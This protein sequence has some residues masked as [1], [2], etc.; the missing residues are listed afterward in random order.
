MKILA[1][2]TETTGL[3]ARQNDIIQLAAIFL[4]G[5][6]GKLVAKGEFITYMKPRS[7]DT[8]TDEALRVNG[9][10]REQM[11]GFIGPGE[12]LY[13]FEEFLSQFIE[14]YN[15]CDKAIPL[16]YNVSFDIDFLSQFY[17]KLENHYLGAWINRRLALDPLP[18]MR[19]IAY[20]GGIKLDSYTLESVCKHLEIPLQA[21]DALEDIRAT[22]KVWERIPE[23]F[24]THKCPKCQTVGKAT[25]SMI[26]CPRCDRDIFISHTQKIRIV[27]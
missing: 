4:E 8:V 7:F 5:E 20:Q 23:F 16:G 19:Y 21:H 6:P 17:L 13:R 2:D 18:L 1:F 27:V 15:P 25:S 22:V 9:I 11:E 14:R 3:D 10:T 24:N 12:A 26:Y